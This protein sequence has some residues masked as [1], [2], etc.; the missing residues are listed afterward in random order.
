MTGIEAVSMDLKLSRHFQ[1]CKAL[2]S[3]CK[4]ST[5]TYLSSIWRPVTA[6][7]MSLDS[8]ARPVIKDP[9]SSNFGFSPGKARVAISDNLARRKSLSGLSTFKLS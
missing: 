3:F 7:S 2:E 6:R 9:K 5:I 4:S 8:S 1:S